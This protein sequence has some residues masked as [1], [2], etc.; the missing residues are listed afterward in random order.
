MQSLAEAK[1]VDE[2]HHDALILGEPVNVVW[3]LQSG[4]TV[5]ERLP[6]LLAVDAVLSDERCGVEFR[7]GRVKFGRLI[8]VWG[9]SA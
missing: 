5:T 6:A 1:A 3:T 8:D 2:Y 9:G 7:A 4:D